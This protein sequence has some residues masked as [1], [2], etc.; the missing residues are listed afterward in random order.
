MNLALDIHVF[1][2]KVSQFD[3]LPSFPASKEPSAMGEET[4]RFS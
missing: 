2:K 4:T 3:N 1:F